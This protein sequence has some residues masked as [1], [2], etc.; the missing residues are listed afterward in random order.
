MRG[1]RKRDKIKVNKIRYLDIENIIKDMKMYV[2]IMLI[3]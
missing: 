1:K 3:C 2:N